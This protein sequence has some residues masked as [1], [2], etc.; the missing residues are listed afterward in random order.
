MLTAVFSHRHTQS[1]GEEEEEEGPGEPESE[2]AGQL[3]V[4]AWLLC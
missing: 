2:V 4:Q 1:E 3:D